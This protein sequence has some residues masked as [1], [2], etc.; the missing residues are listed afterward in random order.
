MQRVKSLNKMWDNKN[1][2]DGGVFTEVIFACHP[3]KKIKSAI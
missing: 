1:C 2:G 3:L